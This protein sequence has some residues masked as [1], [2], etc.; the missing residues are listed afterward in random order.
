MVIESSSCSEITLNGNQKKMVM[1]LTK[2]LV[3]G[4]PAGSY[5]ENQH[6]GST[7]IFGYTAALD[8]LNFSCPSLTTLRAQANRF[9]NFPE[10]N[11]KQILSLP[12][13]LIR[14]FMKTYFLNCGEHT[15]CCIRS[16]III[17]ASI[18]ISLCFIIVLTCN[19]SGDI[20]LII[21]RG[22]RYSFSALLLWDCANSFEE[23]LQGYYAI[24]NGGMEHLS[25]LWQPNGWCEA[26]T[27]CENLWLRSKFQ[28][29][30]A[31][32]KGSH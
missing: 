20:I 3:S 9:H 4:S 27:S 13:Q 17:A 11:R 32:L 19:W 15:I 7:A 25:L 5:I 1:K 14:F 10:L 26:C 29:S 2:H 12:P 21:A 18:I 24:L 28:G 23:L 6:Q 22:M 8:N 31:S 16:H 30:K